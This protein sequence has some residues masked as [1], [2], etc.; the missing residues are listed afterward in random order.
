MGLPESRGDWMMGRWRSVDDGSIGYGVL[1]VVGN[2]ECCMDRPAV[3]T[4]SWVDL[5][6]A[7]CQE[8][9]D[10]LEKVRIDYESFEEKREW[11]QQSLTTSGKILVF[12]SPKKK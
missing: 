6:D 10:A 12:P 5:D 11:Q 7:V 9:F 2:C 4:F 3:R 1:S 8:C